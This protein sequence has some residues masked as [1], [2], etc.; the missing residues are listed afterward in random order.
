MFQTF[1]SAKTSSI[2]WLLTIFN[3]LMMLILKSDDVDDWKVVML[4]LKSDDVAIKKWWWRPRPWWWYWVRWGK[5][6]NMCILLAGS[7]KAFWK[8]KQSAKLIHL[9]VQT[10]V[11]KYVLPPNWPKFGIPELDFE[12]PFQGYPTPPAWKRCILEGGVSLQR[13]FK[14][15]SRKV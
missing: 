2:L 14:M 3:T 9:D 7:W 4:I 1:N 5:L 13:A 15:R 10:Y 6:Q 11:R 12:S 8:L